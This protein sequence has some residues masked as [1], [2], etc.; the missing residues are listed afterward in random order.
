MYTLRGGEGTADWDTA[1]SNRPT[2]LELLDRE[3]SVLFQQE[4]KLEKLE[5]NN[6]SSNNS[7]LEIRARWGFPTISS[8]VPATRR[9]GL[10]GRQLGSRGLQE[11]CLAR[12]RPAWFVCCLCV[13]TYIYIYIYKCVYCNLSIVFC[14]IV[15]IYI[16]ICIHTYIHMLF[17]SWY[18]Y[19]PPCFSA[20]PI[21]WV[22]LLV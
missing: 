2:C 4:D 16:Y 18:P 3:L 10:R 1:A 5:L 9:E 6:L 21:T 11:A 17:R 13:Y 12:W 20:I 7:N 8:P 14:Y 15:Y 19:H 22:A